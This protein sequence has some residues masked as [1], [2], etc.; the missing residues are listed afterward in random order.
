MD[1]ACSNDGPPSCPSSTGGRLE[2]WRRCIRHNELAKRVFEI[3]A[4]ENRV[5]TERDLFNTAFAAMVA[6]L[7]FRDR[8]LRPTV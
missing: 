5:K 2:V 3:W 7:P 4:I 6:R 8:M 1:Y